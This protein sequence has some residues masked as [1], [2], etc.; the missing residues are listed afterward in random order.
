MGKGKRK[1]R[2]QD[3]ITERVVLATAIINLI[4]TALDIVHKLIE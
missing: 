4:E 3:H 2:R 1:S